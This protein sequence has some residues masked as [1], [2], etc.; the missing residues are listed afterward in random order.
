MG[1][2]IK[3]IGEEHISSLEEREEGTGSC[4]VNMINS[5]KFDTAARSRRMREFVLLAT[6][7][8]VKDTNPMIPFM[9]PLTVYQI[10]TTGRFLDYFARLD[11]FP[12]D[13]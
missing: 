4:A 3:D 13:S 2:P 5:S 7:V 8:A 6:I 12:L 1:F 10:A 11:D 9:F